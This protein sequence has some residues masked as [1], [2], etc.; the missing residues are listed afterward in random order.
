MSREWVW[1]NPVNLHAHVVLSVERGAQDGGP[2]FSRH[3]R[4][5]ELQRALAYTRSEITSGTGSGRSADRLPAPKRVA[6]IH[7][8]LGDRYVY[9]RD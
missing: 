5:L 1:S 4:L 3:E 9:S 7:A 6:S 8:A 2:R